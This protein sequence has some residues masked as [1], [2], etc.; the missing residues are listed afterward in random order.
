MLQFTLAIVWIDSLFVNIGIGDHHESQGR[1]VKNPCKQGEHLQHHV[2]WQRIHKNGSGLNGLSDFYNQQETSYFQKK[3]WGRAE[4]YSQVLP[5]G[6][7]R[8]RNM[9]SNGYNNATQCDNANLFLLWVIST[10]T[11]A[12]AWKVTLLL[13]GCYLAPIGLSVTPGCT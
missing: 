11:A 4:H 8:V 6:Y 10:F 2:S 13:C 1:P 7:S 12:E 5:W 3:S 9:Q